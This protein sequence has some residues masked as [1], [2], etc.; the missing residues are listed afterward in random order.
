M[1]RPEAAATAG[2]LLS[3]GGGPL[4]YGGQARWLGDGWSC[5]ASLLTDVRAAERSVLLESGRIRP[6]VVWDILLTALRQRAARGVDVCLRI[7]SAP[8][9]REAGHM[10]I[11]V[12]RRSPPFPAGTAALIDGRIR[13]AGLPALCDAFAGLRKTPWITACLRWEAG[14]GDC[15]ALPA[16]PRSARTAVLSMA[17][18]AERSFCLTAPRRSP[19]PALRAALRM[20]AESGVQVRVVSGRRVHAIAC[21]ADDRQA[22]TGG[23]WVCSGTYIAG[24]MEGFSW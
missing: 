22:F 4:L 17:G 9:L 24:T 19:D 14:G 7:G 16:G 8:G 18:R 10:H 20:A 11:R 6:G 3:H 21:R 13:Y 23:L 1:E 15:Y 2:A 12:E 5:F